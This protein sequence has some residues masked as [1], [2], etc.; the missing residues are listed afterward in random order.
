MDPYYIASSKNHI[1]AHNNFSLTL[2]FDSL[3]SIR[4]GL[5]YAIMLYGSEWVKIFKFKKISWI[6]L[7]MYGGTNLYIE[8]I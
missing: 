7:F 6:F 4:I 5:R 1:M 8:E 3:T 2:I